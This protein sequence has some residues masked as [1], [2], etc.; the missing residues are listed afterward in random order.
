[1]ENSVPYSFANQGYLPIQRHILAPDG[2]WTAIEQT[3]HI[4]AAAFNPAPLPETLAPFTSAKLTDSRYGSLASHS[5]VRDTNKLVIHAQAWGGTIENQVTRHEAHRIAQALPDH[6]ITSLTMPG[7]GTEKPSSR[8]PMAVRMQMLKTGSFTK[9]GQHLASL[10]HAHPFVKTA[11]TIDVLGTSTGARSAISLAAHLGKKVGNL[12]LF[13]P[14]GSSDLG[15]KTFKQR[16]RITEKQHGDQYRANSLDAQHVHVMDN[17]PS[18][19]SLPYIKAFVRRDPLAAYDF[20]HGEVAAMAR[21]HLGRDLRNL[22][23]VGRVV[24]LSPEHSALND[25][26]DMRDTVA[27]AQNRNPH[28]TFE[29]YIFPG[30]HTIT[31]MAS[32]VLAEFFKAAL[33]QKLLR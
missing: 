15:V 30:T 18:R 11:E 5:I 26:H 12:I 28:T 13:D 29:H 3:L 7:H 21:P 16:F 4:P 31:R 32:T 19:T 25:I 1:M 20:Y 23:N 27:M 14:P 24:V 6:T 9:A 10:M 2:A 8:R 17:A 22:R 33:H